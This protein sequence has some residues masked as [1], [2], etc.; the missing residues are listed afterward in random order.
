CQDNSFSG[1]GTFDAGGGDPSY[2]WTGTGKYT[3]SGSDN[4]SAS[5]D[6]HWALA[7][8][9]TWQASSGSGSGSGSQIMDW[10]ENSSGDYTYPVVGGEVSGT[11]NG[12][13]H[14]HSETNATENWTL[15]ANGD[16]VTTGTWDE[17]TSGGWND[18][19]AGSGTYNASGGDPS[20]NWTGTGTITQSGSDDWTYNFGSSYDI[21]PDGTWVVV[22][23]S[24]QGHG[25]QITDW[26]DDSGGDYTYVVPGGQV[27][28][29]WA[30]SSNDHSHANSTEDWTLNPDGN[31]VRT[32]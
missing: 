31:W 17:T 18:S 25:T 22:G 3:E 7:A 26:T 11:W 4:W 14:E 1:N 20:Y 16:W 30:E 24:G 29:T 19:Y 23:G 6:S 13:S 15:P 21:Q 8:N 2:W 5:Y 9:G 28:G 12:A 27:T 32:G 10:S